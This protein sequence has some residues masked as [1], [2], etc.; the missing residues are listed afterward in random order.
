[1]VRL[2]RNPSGF[3]LPTGSQDGDLLYVQSN[4][5]QRRAIG[6]NGQFLSVNSGLPN[7]AA[8]L[9][10]IL[11][12]PSQAT[13][14]L[15]YKS[16]GGY[17]RLGIGST[18]QVLTLAGGLPSWA[19]PSTASGDMQGTPLFVNSSGQTLTRNRYSVVTVASATV[20]LPSVATIGWFI[21]V[22]ASSTAVTISA[23]GT[24][25]HNRLI[26]AFGTGFIYTNVTLTDYIG[27]FNIST[28]TTSTVVYAYTGADQV[29]PVPSWATV[30][31]FKLWAAAGGGAFSAASTRGGAG[32][33]IGFDMAVIGNENLIGRVGQ[34][35]YSRNDNLGARTYGGGG[36]PRSAAA[37]IFIGAG[38]GFTALYRSSLLLG[39]TGGGGGAG[40]TAGVAGGAGGAAVGNN[41]VGTGAGVGGTQSAGGTVGGAALL[42]GIGTFNYAGAGGSGFFGGGAATADGG[43][44]AGGSSFIDSSATNTVQAAGSGFTPGNNSD[45]AYIAGVGVGGLGTA[46]GLTTAIGGNGLLV[47]T[48]RSV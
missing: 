39:L 41:A 10:T 13:G 8:Q 22:N 3:T 26:P 27:N 45:P 35:G 16:S 31:A 47:V 5:L 46:D 19:S 40:I 36:V 15:Y 44:G 38:A 28:A 25:L 33:F 21:V 14:D 24:A 23:T 12:I 30:S 20:V 6:I 32:A 4:A 2:L 29:V 17:A 42:G 37:G 34:G 18:G 11:S 43:A 9:D 1:M 48:H 7:W